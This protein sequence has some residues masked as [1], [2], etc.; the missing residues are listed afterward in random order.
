MKVLKMLGMV[1]HIQNLAPK[2]TSSGFKST[3]GI[4]VHLH[5]ATSLP[6]HSRWGAATIKWLKLAGLVSILALIQRDVV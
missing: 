4:G 3:E 6:R 1:C 5:T 2:N